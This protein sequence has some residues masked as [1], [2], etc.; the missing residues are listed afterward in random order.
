MYFLMEA[1]PM[2][3]TYHKDL[4]SIILKLENLIKVLL[5]L[6]LEDHLILIPIC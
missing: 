4:G 6:F 2:Q 3:S 1:R 5:Q